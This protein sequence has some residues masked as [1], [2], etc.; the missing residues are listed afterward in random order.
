MFTGL[1]TGIGAVA[2]R[3][4]RGPGARLSLRASFGALEVGE[5]IAVDG[6]CVTVARVVD[7]GFEVDLTAET[8]ACTTLGTVAPDAAVNLERSLAVGERLGGHFVTGHV[9]GIGEILSRREVGEAAAVTFGLPAALAR[10][11]AKKGSI[12]VNGVSL[13][14]NDVRADRLEVMLIPVT[15]SATNLGRLAAGQRVNIEVDLVARYVARLLEG[16]DLPRDPG[17]S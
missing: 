2:R 10:F 6:C 4:A 9:D 3:E 7:G 5:S 1:V 14:V 8:L 16:Q 12:A 13:T 11:V 15:L 17:A